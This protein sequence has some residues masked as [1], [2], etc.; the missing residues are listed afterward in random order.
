[1]G[2]LSTVQP[3]IGLGNDLRDRGGGSAAAAAV[4]ELLHDLSQ[5]LSAIRV[6]TATPLACDAA[7]GRDR[8]AKERLR[9][10]GELA[11]W[12]H[13]LLGQGS[14]G[15]LGSEPVEWAN[16]ADVIADVLV[17]AAASFQ[18]E[19][20]Y[21]P[22]APAMVPVG[23]VKLRRA[24]GNVVDN[25]MRAAGPHGRVEVRVRLIRSRL[26]LEVIDD[27]PGFGHVAP[28]S[29]RGLATTQAVLDHCGGTLQIVSRRPGGSIVRLEIPL[30]G[31]HSQP[32]AAPP[33]A[34]DVRS[35][36]SSSATIIAS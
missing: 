26:R 18:G 3:E 12:M 5:P 23:P 4:A 25:A 31:R 8:E 15:V 33:S 21:R 1:L 20:R 11:D 34:T 14:K 17:A 29:G 24:L 30:A 2:V 13:D 16:A 6:L 9:Q 28:R 7:E 36:E 19:I 22:C 35:C 10:I 27:G 32:V